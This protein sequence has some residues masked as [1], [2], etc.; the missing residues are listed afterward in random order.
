MYGGFR[1]VGLK[2]KHLRGETRMAMFYLIRHAACQDPGILSG[3]SDEVT[4]SPE[5]V[6]QAQALAEML[7]DKDISALYS[8]PVL[9]AYQSADFLSRAFGLN[10][11]LEDSFTEIDYGEW[12]GYNV[13]E[14]KANQEWREYNA[15]RSLKRIPGGESLFEVTQRMVSGIEKLNG[16]YPDK[17]IAIVSHQDP[18]KAALMYFLGMAPDLISRLVISAASVS[19]VILNNW[20]AEVGYINK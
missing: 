7:R 10:V 5:G 4:L 19:A 15:F 14:L 16:L 1:F 12:T 2:R 8:S 17:S 20:G 3:R 13:E 9:R 18:I 6:K 11:V